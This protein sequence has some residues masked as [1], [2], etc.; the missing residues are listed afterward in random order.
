MIKTIL[1]PLESFPRKTNPAKKVVAFV[2]C[3]L[4]KEYPVAAG[5]A[6]FTGCTLE[7][8]IHGR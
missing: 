4:G 5:I 1:N 3:P 2:V 8:S 7:S 6:S